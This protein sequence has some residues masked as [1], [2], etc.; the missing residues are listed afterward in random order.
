MTPTPDACT[1]TDARG[2]ADWRCARCGRLLARTDVQ[3]GRVEI[4]CPRC[5]PRRVEVLVVRESTI[6]AMEGR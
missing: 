4:V 6:K 1:V 2:L 5:R 3:A